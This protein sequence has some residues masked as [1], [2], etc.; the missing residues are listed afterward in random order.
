MLEILLYSIAGI[1][2]GIVTGL[3][4][5]IHVNLIAVLI[6]ALGVDASYAPFIVALAIT[7]SFLDVIPAILLGAPESATAL[8]VLPGH[9]Y[10]LHGNGLMAIKLTLIGSYFG[11][12]VAVVLIPVWWKIISLYEYIVPVM[13]Y[14]LLTVSA[15]MI[16]R[17]NK[18]FWALIVYA[19]SAAL[20]WILLN[21]AVIDEP[22]F[23]LFSGLFGVATLLYSLH[24][25]TSIPP[26][27]D[28]RAIDIRIGDSTQAILAGNASGF[29]TSMLP[30]L[31]SAQAAILAMNVTRNIG[32]HGFLVMIGTINTVNFAL[33]LL[34]WLGLEKARNGAIVAITKLTEPTTQLITTLL[35]VALI[36]GSIAVPLCLYL[37]RKTL[38]LLSNVSY[39]KVCVFVIVL[40]TMLVLLLGG[41][42]G[43]LILCV[44]TALGLIPAI[45]K[46]GR[47]HAM[48]C[49]LFP[50]ALYFL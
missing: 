15:Y 3:I 50:V 2:A 29:L 48:G 18:R 49:L 25:K 26:Q 20:G 16:L 10:L 31:G 32:D 5:G 13:G 22:L 27:K 35:L 1:L 17:D 21:N 11:L 23:P 36:A 42:R 41:I 7:H 45:T 46:C 39:T 44:A 30:G 8:G 43:I 34:T 4:P 19:L 47:A 9:R 14:V 40:I 24:Q 37:S 33:S 38:R 12:L 28:S 6:L